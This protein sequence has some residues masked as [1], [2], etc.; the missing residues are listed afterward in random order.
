MGPSPLRRAEAGAG[1]ES[2]GA[3]LNLISIIIIGGLHVETAMVAAVAASESLAMLPLD[4]SAAVLT[5]GGERSF[6]RRL[7]E[8]GF[9]PGTAVI[10]RN[11]APMGDPIEI[12][13]RGSRVSIRRA[14]ASQIQ[15][16]R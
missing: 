15:V 8:L 6:R 13:V 3:A 14:E 12:Q 9:V 1:R 10:V 4:Q 5:V 2:I 16:R 11:V 7:L